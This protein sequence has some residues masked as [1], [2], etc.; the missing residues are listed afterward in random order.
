MKVGFRK[1]SLK[2][3]ISARTSPARF[4]RHSLGFKA[5]RGWGWVTNPQRALYN[6]VYH[7]TTFGL[8]DLFGG[9]SKRSKASSSGCL[10]AL[11]FFLGIG[12][13]GRAS[14]ST[15]GA[16][17]LVLI[18]VAA[19]M[20]FLFY[21]KRQQKEKEER[22]IVAAEEFEV[23]QRARVI[24]ESIDLVNNSKNFETRISRLE[25]AIS[26]LEEI[27]RKYPH[28]ADIPGELAKAYAHRLSLYTAAVEAKVEKQMETSRARKTVKAKIN[29]A[30]LA[31]EVV[32]QGLLSPHTD[33]AKLQHFKESIQ[34]Y[35]QRVE[36]G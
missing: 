10:L 33:K 18:A 36:E 17:T 19:A 7:R 2:G 9:G 15:G 22:A 14:E 1:P 26:H 8:G 13:V 20:G 35:I 3:M 27:N 29:A 28:R 12:V 6:R 5:P 34:E 11:L 16:V 24:T 25:I 31:M 21:V 4:V 23:A 32:E 30:N